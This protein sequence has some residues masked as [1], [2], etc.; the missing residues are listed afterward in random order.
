MVRLC[1]SYARPKHMLVANCH[2]ASRLHSWCAAVQAGVLLYLRKIGNGMLN[3]KSALQSV[4]YL[5]LALNLIGVST[6]VAA[7]VVAY[8]YLSLRKKAK[9]S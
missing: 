8:Q 3:G 7:S 9:G 1:N 2:S 4:E 5:E 6:S